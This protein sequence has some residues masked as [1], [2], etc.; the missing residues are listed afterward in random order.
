MQS[1]MAASVLTVGSPKDLILSKFVRLEKEKLFTSGDPLW[2]GVVV[3]EI[4][5]W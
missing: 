3:E 2:K 1:V 5:L 4:W